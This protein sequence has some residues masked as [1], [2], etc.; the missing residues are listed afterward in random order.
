MSGLLDLP[1][2]ALFQ[3]LHSM[4]FCDYVR[5]SSVCRAILELVYF[6]TSNI[7]NLE[8]SVKSNAVDYL[9]KRCKKLKRPRLVG[10]LSCKKLKQLRYRWPNDIHLDWDWSSP[11][12]ITSFLKSLTTSKLRQIKHMNIKIKD[13]SSLMQTR[14]DWSYMDLQSLSIECEGTSVER[15]LTRLNVR[16]WDVDNFFVRGDVWN[17]SECVLYFPNV[18]TSMTVVSTMQRGSCFDQ[19]LHYAVA[20]LVNLNVNVRL[21]NII[22][23]CCTDCNIGSSFALGVRNAIPQH[24]AENKT[25]RIDLA[26]VDMIDALVSKDINVSCGLFSDDVDIITNEFDPY[27]VNIRYVI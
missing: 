7:T 19:E 9:C 8:K 20:F 17:F 27:S 18:H 12:S 23:V 13:N 4:S 5:C 25:W 21:C 3:I 15:V 14:V 22:D 11:S 10:E 1:Q 2:D 26:T 24:N 16:Q 6:M